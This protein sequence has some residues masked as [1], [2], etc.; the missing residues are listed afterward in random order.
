MKVSCPENTLS[1]RQLRTAGHPGKSQLFLTLEQPNIPLH[2][3]ARI[4]ERKNPWG[5][6]LCFTRSQALEGWIACA[7]RL[8]NLRVEDNLSSLLLLVVSRKQPVG[9]ERERKKC[10]LSII[11]SPEKQKMRRWGSMRRTIGEMGAKGNVTEHWPETVTGGPAEGRSLD[12][13]IQQYH[14]L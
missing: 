10:W 5:R 2:W 14:C 13:S 12:Q 6:T 8:G 4:L 11:F 3:K 9:Q 7:G 1:L